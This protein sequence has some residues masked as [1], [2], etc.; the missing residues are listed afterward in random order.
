M[1]AD[2]YVLVDLGMLGRH[3]CRRCELAERNNPDELSRDEWL[4]LMLDR[5]VAIQTDKRVRTGSPQPSCDFP[6]PASRTSTFLAARARPA[7]HHGAR[8]G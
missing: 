3:S 4:G 1:A 2:I 5:E 7:Q 6:K 8:E